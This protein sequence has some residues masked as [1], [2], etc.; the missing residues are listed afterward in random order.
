MKIHILGGS[1]TGKS[2]LSE[3]I[4]KRYSIKHYDLDDIF[5]D[6]DIH[7][8][9]VKVPAQERDRNLQKILEDE[10]WVIEGV[11]Y[12]WLSTSFEKADRIILLTTPQILWDLR[13]LNR[14]LQRKLGIAP[15]RKEE[16][17]LSLINLIRWT[18]RYQKNIPKIL[19]FLSPYQNKVLV[20]NKIADVF[21]ELDD[22]YESRR[23]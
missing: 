16:T 5:W 11:Y 23:N 3:I 21:K 14:F 8:Y 13:I 19:D 12:K 22:L 15:A 17:L 2:Y 10:D 9:G 18:N 4:S 20:T 7:T 1:G 6:N